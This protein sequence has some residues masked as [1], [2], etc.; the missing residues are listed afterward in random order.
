MFSR[1]THFPRAVHDHRSISFRRKPH[2]DSGDHRHTHPTSAIQVTSSPSWCILPQCKPTFYRIFKKK[3]SQGYQSI[4]YLVALFSSMLW[5]YYACLKS[6]AMLLIT[7]NSVGCV[8]ETTYIAMFIA[9]ASKKARMTTLKMLLLLNFGGFSLIVLCV[10]YLA[11]GPNRVR[12]LGWVCLVFNVSVFVSPLSI[13]KQVIR[14]KSVEFMPFSLSFFLTLNAVVWFF[15]GLL[16][17]NFYIYLPNTLRFA[18][19][20]LQMVLY[21]IYKSCDEVPEDQKPSTVAEQGTT[22]A[23]DGFPI[24]SLANR[25]ETREKNDQN[26][27]DRT[28]NRGGHRANSYHV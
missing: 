27:H 2:G 21:L 7:I 18:F 9:Y 11:K 8:I 3:S 16:Q 13:M 5:I 14:T 25:V 6:N 1:R 24:F 22:E 28:D 17:K 20:I 10:Y 23:P 15:Y 12:V 19:G 26:V 4:P